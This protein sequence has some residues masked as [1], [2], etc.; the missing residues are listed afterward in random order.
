MNEMYNMS[1]VT[2]YYGVV[3]VLGAIFFNLLM[4]K[5]ADDI[6]K[7]KRFNTLFNPI[8]ATFIG[9]VIFTGVIMMA[10]K[11]LDFTVE[12]LLMIIFAVV[13]IVLEVKRS[14]RLKYLR[15]SDDF[16]TYKLYAYKLF[17]IE[18]FVT[19]MISAWMLI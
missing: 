13:F 4:L 6:Q 14:K 5:K 17:G 12:N 1:I 8:N 15:V 7:Y 16:D 19:I 2:H 11:H 18:L 10:A 9:T 3:A